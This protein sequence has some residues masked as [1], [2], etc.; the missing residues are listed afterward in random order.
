MF[1]RYFQLLAVKTN[2]PLW[3]LMRF[4]NG[5][6]LVVNQIMCACSVGHHQYEY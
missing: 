2:D 1:S 6:S 5:Y 4:P 3:P